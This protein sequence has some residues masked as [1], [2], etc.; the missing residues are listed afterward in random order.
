VIANGI[1]VVGQDFTGSGVF[2]LSF[3][4]YRVRTEDAGKVLSTIF[5]SQIS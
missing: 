3:F 1:P 5:S 4:G 2:Q